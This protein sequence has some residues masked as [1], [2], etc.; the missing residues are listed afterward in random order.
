MKNEE[1]FIFKAHSLTE[2]LASLA[3]I[4]ANLIAGFTRSLFCNA[5]VAAA[6]WEAALRMIWKRWCAN[7][8]P[9]PIKIQL[10]DL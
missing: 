3:N 1:D 6:G 10:G 2:N 9:E 4:R 5:E 7:L 8:D